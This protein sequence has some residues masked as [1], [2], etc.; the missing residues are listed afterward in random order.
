MLTSC[1]PSPQVI[2]ECL[3]RHRVIN[4]VVLLNFRLC[5]V[6]VSCEESLLRG[7]LASA[8]SGH[9][10]FSHHWRK[11]VGCAKRRSVLYRMLHACNAL[12]LVHKLSEIQ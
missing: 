3:N 6:A 7:Q 1:E 2:A 12:C 10:H 11:R 8:L 4:G 9:K 5:C